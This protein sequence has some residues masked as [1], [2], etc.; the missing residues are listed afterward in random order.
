MELDQRN[1]ITGV[2]ERINRAG[3]DEESAACSA[4]ERVDNDNFENDFKYSL[5]L[6]LKV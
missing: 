1:G 6:S 2:H 5:R 4:P 3:L